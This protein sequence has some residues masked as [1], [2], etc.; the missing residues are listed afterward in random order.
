MATAFAA[1]SMT[2][3][4]SLA[5][6]LIPGLSDPTK[7]FLFNQDVP[8]ALDPS[9]IYPDDDEVTIEVKPG[10]TDVGLVNKWRFP[11]GK[12]TPIWGYAMPGAEPTWPGMTFEAR[13]DVI[14]KV[15]WEN[16]LPIDS[17]EPGHLISNL[18]G[19]V[20]VVDESL[21]WVYSLPG[22]EEFTLESEGVPVVVHLHGGHSEFKSDGNPVR[23]LWLFGD[24][25]STR[26][27]TQ[28]AFF[29]DRNFSFPPSSGSRDLNGLRPAT[30]T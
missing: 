4:K 15:I 19:E 17:G 12:T 29:F 28:Y 23:F 10:M 20:D 2:V 16:M 1:V 3:P 22:R 11:L 21:H 14:K 8:N 25:Q 7:Q 18:T 24:F 27:L 13:K 6:P 5:D 9:F 26:G 30:R